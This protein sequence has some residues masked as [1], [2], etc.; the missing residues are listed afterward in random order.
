M[1]TSLSQSVGLGRR[2][3]SLQKQLAKK[4]SSLLL[5]PEVDFPPKEQL[6]LFD[7]ETTVAFVFATLSSFKALLH[8]SAAGMLEEFALRL[9]DLIGP[10]AAHVRLP[11]EFSIL[12]SVPDEH[13]KNF[14]HVDSIL[15]EP[16]MADLDSYIFVPTQQSKRFLALSNVLQRS[17]SPLMLLGPC[18]SGKS[19]LLSQMIAQ[20]PLRETPATLPATYAAHCGKAVPTLGFGPRAELLY[21]SAA[22]WIQPGLWER[23]LQSLTRSS[24]TGLR[25]RLYSWCVFVID[26]CHCANESLGEAWR[27]NMERWDFRGKELTS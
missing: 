12:D 16:D 10:A 5:L 17:Q 8:D 2:K 6:I 27:F 18:G 14:Y 22:H 24:K 4:A 26:D 9:V 7:S 19:L 11:V 15:K 21:M 25:P 13:L 1:D 3:S 20:L 23:S